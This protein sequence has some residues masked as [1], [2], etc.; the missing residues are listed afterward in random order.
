MIYRFDK[1]KLKLD[2]MGYD[3]HTSNATR[4]MKKDLTQEAK[5]GN[6]QYRSDGVYLTVDGKEYKGYMYHKYP[7][8]ALYGMPKFHITECTTIQQQ[9]ATGRFDNSYF[10]QNTSVVTLTDRGNGEVHNDVNLVLCN[11]CRSQSRVP[12]R[13][14]EAFF[15]SLGNM[16][17]DPNLEVEVD[18]MGYPIRPIN[19]NEVSKRYREEKNYTCE[20][21]SCG[22]V[23]KE[24]LDKRFIHV[25]HKDGNK[26]NC[27]KSNLE[28]LCV[29]CHSQSDEKHIQN[30]QKARLESEINAFLKKYSSELTKLGNKFIGSH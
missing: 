1:L 30:F 4:I 28:C 20:H 16:M 13:S 2:Q 7:N 9:K 5:A 26:L 12:Y 27:A 21:P 23:I 29:L 10:W 17:N 25:H 14:T 19:W 22:V 3:S 18:I 8:I 24:P 6:I 11:N 15:E